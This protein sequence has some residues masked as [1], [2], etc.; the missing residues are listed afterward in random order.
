MQPGRKHKHDERQEVG[1]GDQ[2]KE[3]A[4]AGDEEAVMWLKTMKSPTSY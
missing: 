3:A 2:E 4:E 1:L